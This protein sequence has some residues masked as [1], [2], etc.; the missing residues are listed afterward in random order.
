MTEYVFLSRPI[1]NLSS[2]ILR[3]ISHTTV[4]SNLIRIK[5]YEVW[6]FQIENSNSF[7]NLNDLFENLISFSWNIFKKKHSSAGSFL[8]TIFINILWNW[9]S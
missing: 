3:N 9:R 7:N 1:L 6:V 8:R 2:K 5:S 4:V